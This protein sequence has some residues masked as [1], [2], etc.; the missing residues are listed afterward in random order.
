MISVFR[1]VKLLCGYWLKV[2]EAGVLF[3]GTLGVNVMI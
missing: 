3:M 1:M 2:I